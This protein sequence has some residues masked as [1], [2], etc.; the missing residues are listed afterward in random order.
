L[1]I[2]TGAAEPD[3][4]SSTRRRTA[5]GRPTRRAN[6]IVT[7]TGWSPLPLTNPFGT[8]DRTLTHH[9]T[10]PLAGPFVVR[11]LR[12]AASF[13]NP[14]PPRRRRRRRRHFLI[15]GFFTRTRRGGLCVWTRRRRIRQARVVHAFKR[16]NGP[17]RTE[18]NAKFK[19]PRT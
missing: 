12:A 16:R 9:R 4:S 8:A 15:A 10:P 14:F 2:P 11:R 13:L 7:A 1:A 18:R 6:A 19:C 5:D 17:E 3:F